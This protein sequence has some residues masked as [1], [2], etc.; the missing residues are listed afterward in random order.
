MRIGMRNATVVFMALVCILTGVFL[1]YVHPTSEQHVDLRMP[2]EQAALAKGQGIEVMSPVVGSKR[3]SD[4]CLMAPQGDDNAE[5]AALRQNLDAARFLFAT[6]MTVLERDLVLDLSGYRRNYERGK[7]VVRN[8]PISTSPPLSKERRFALG[9]LLDSVSLGRLLGYGSW[10][11]EVA[12]PELTFG[13]REVAKAIEHGVTPEVLTQLLELSGVDPTVTSRIN[14]AN[15]AKTAAVHGKPELLRV[16]LERGANPTNG[17]RS[18]LDDLALV[19]PEQDDGTYADV[20]QQLLS[21]GDM[22]YMPSTLDTLEAVTPL[23]VPSSLHP[24][25]VA[26]IDTPEVRRTAE[27]FR[28]LMDG[29]ADRMRK[30]VAVEE[31][32][33]SVVVQAPT[34]SSL[35]AKQTYEERLRADYVHDPLVR[36]AE[37]ALAAAEKMILSGE[38]PE[39]MEAYGRMLDLWHAGMWSA[40]F[41]VAEEWDTGWYEAL[42]ERAL[43]HGAPFE[44]IEE[45]VSRNGGNVPDDAMV[46]LVSEPWSGAAKLATILREVYTMD[47]HYVDEDG[48]NA[49]YYISEQFYDLQGPVCAGRNTEVWEMAQFL[50]EQGVAVKSSARGLDPLDIVLLKAIKMPT[51]VAAATDFVRLLIDKGAPIDPSHREL[52]QWLAQYNPEGYAELVETVPELAT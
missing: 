46:L 9:E 8:H 49:F 37:L 27:Q 40:A 29:W 50:A 39:N 25:A 18:V 51:T 48:R 17:N 38:V 43:L 35:F 6:G 47:V 42:V 11:S 4:D 21:A 24:D 19:M 41:A 12:V 32:C 34:T 1:L 36:E 31:R 20:V 28:A 26:L 33:A 14:G 3:S 23:T 30:A 52:M 2:E 15:L 44:I 22:P 7:V 16:L 45:V 5:L 10:R 13:A